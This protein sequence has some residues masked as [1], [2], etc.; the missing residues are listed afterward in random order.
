[1]MMDETYSIPAR[2]GPS[3]KG[4]YQRRRNASLLPVLRTTQNKAVDSDD[5]IYFS[6]VTNYK[7]DAKRK[8]APHQKP[9]SGAIH[10]RLLMTSCDY[11]I[12][13]SVVFWKGEIHCTWKNPDLPPTY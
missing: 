8:I 2:G 4:S 10:F 11:D 1:M 13:A 5:L 9:P 6:G 3:A 7:K 12:T